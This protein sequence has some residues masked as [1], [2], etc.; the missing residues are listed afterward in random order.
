MREGEK[1]IFEPHAMYGCAD[2]DDGDPFPFGYVSSSRLMPIFELRPV[3]A[4][5]PEELAAYARLMVVAPDMLEALEQLL[6][7]MGEDGLS[8]CQAAK[9]MASAAILKARAES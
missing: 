1:W 3:L 8:V 7:D 9:D 5:T 2:P 6:D 4:Y